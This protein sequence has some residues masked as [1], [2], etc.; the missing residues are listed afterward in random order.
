MSIR[1]RVLSPGSRAVN[2]FLALRAAISRPADVW[3]ACRMLG[4]A[5]VLPFLKH[6]LPLPRLAQLMWKPQSGPHRPGREEQVEALARWFY[7]RRLPLRD[8]CL[9]RA[10]LMYRYLAD[11]GAEPRLVVGVSSNQPKT[12]GHVWLTLNDEPLQESDA[13]LAGFVPVL[14]FG[15]GGVAE[16]DPGT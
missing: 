6:A 1:G 9:E 3:L 12:A 2:R 13:T 15:S 5:L 4:W 14:R 16:P 7:G 10:L 11:A 8:N